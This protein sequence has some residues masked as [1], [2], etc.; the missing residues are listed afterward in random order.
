MNDNTYQLGFAFLLTGLLGLW[1]HTKNISRLTKISSILPD[2]LKKFH[3]HLVAA[4]LGCI[5]ITPF[6]AIGV[7]QKGWPFGHFGCQSYAFAGMF[8]G[9][10][11]IYL[12]CFICFF[13]MVEI[14]NLTHI[15][16]FISN[17]YNYI[18]FGIWMIGALWAILP[19]YGYGRYTLE[20][21][22]TSCLLDWTNMD[23]S[24][25]LYMFSLMIFGYVLPFGIGIWSQY[26]L[27]QH[28]VSDANKTKKKNTTKIEI[29]IKLNNSILLFNIFGWLSYGLLAINSLIS[30]QITLNPFTY[31][32]PQLLAKISQAFL[33]IAYSYTEKQIGQWNKAYGNIE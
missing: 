16:H 28:T 25:K 11:S 21:H 33:P 10:T 18:P 20:P 5:A 32:I 7:Y 14:L 23:E 22:K 30:G 27:I 26:K 4:C 2:G 19:L 12:S 3:Y 9:M 1:L 24:M 29:L 6:S 13:T 15:R 31:C 17:Q 8:F